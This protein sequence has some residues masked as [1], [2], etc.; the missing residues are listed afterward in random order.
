MKKALIIA[1]ALL[2]GCFTAWGDDPTFRVGA[3]MLSGRD[4]HPTPGVTLGIDINTPMPAGIGIFSD[5]YL[6]PD[7]GGMKPTTFVGMNT[8]YKSTSIEENRKGRVYFGGGG[9]LM[10]SS[11]S[12]LFVNGVVGGN[13]KVTQGV[14]VFVQTKFYYVPKGR[15]NTGLHVGVSF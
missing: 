15:W 13:V 1:I 14:N 8:L 9:G 4:A 12:R 6:S 5:F 2:A 3:G 10:N 7:D 11:V